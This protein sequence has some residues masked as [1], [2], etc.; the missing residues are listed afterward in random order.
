M[1]NLSA[2]QRRERA[3]AAAS[4]ISA[5]HGIKSAV[6]VLLK[7][8]NNTIIHLA[9][10]PVV[11][12][13]AT[14]TLRKRHD[15][16]LEHELQVALH[17]AR[18]GAPIVPPSRE[19]PPVVYLVNGLEITFWQYCPGEVREEIDRAELMDAIREFHAAL[20]DYE[21]E[22][23]I[24]T[25][26]YEEC[27]SLLGTDGLSPELSQAHRRFLRRVYE[28]LRASLQTFRYDCVPAHEEIHAGNILW[29]EGKPLLID[30]ESCCLAPREIDF[31][32]F[33]DG[34]LA[35]LPHLD[36]RLME[37]LSVCK[38]FCVAVWCWSQPERAPEVRA[39]AEYHLD[40]LYGLNL[41]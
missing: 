2:R 25:R 36:R 41:S 37:L 39:A 1:E 7:D 27:Y 23:K 17:L 6:P 38:S 16:N 32:P 10:S 22:L 11:A 8:S 14:S 30:F 35:S 5:A 40:R 13:V 20:A 34:N 29:M 18:A 28:Q 15:S 31:L 24:F 21:G 3:L 19:L 26:K 12:K 33:S 4:E 9:P